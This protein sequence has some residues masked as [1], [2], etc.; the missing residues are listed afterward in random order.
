MGRIHKNFNMRPLHQLFVVILIVS[1]AS[2]SFADEDKQKWIPL[3]NGK[4]LEGWV[5]KIRYQKSGEDPKNTFRVEDGMIKVR[6][7]KY[8]EF[9]E[10]FG[11][12]FYELPFSHYRLRLEYR[13]VGEQVKGGPSWAV[14]NS[15]VM[16]HGQSPESM[17]VDQKF[18]ASIEVQLL[19]GPEGTTKRTTANLCTPGTHVFFGDT[20]EKRHC[21]G[22]E[23][24]T[25]R[26]DQWV[27][28]EIEVRG[29]EVIRH[30]V[31]GEKVMEYHKPVLD[32]S[33]DT[34]KPLIKAAKGEIGLSEGTIS[35]Q[36]ESHPCDFRKVEIQVL[37]K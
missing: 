9:E 24:K 18:P 30:F 4:D 27:T 21:T 26:G 15:G 14:R 36:S 23:S 33:D 2:S 25:F 5:P 37:K 19:G 3:F 16:V 13:F 7:D 32:D 11:H 20:L 34:A 6:Y 10:T 1:S 35:L 28:V 22:S 31:N 29:N 8:E 17:A 12:L